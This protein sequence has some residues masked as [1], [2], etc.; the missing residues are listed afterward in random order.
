MK[1]TMSKSGFF[2]W[3]FGSDPKKGQS[4]PPSPNPPSDN[5]PAQ[6]PA[7][8][9]DAGPASAADI[10]H[11]TFDDKD[12][13]IP[14]ASRERL[15]LC[16]AL[17]E[18]IGPR[19]ATEPAWSPVLAELTQMT[20]QHLPKLIRSYLEIPPQHRAEIFRKTGRSASYVLNDGL[21]KIIARLR[22]ISLHLAQDTLN[23]FTANTDFID[24]R[25]GDDNK[26]F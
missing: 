24:R 12:D 13:A 9:R 23:S 22:E 2:S 7:P 25:Y 19:A 4:R 16:R 20:D 1:R 11:F 3:L 18:D 21:D 10:P 15:A 8:P 17:I 26:P 6:N 5:P 14:P